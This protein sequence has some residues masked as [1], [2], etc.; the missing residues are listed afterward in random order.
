MTTGTK[1]LEA[2]ALYTGTGYHRIEHYRSGDTSPGT[3]YDD[4]LL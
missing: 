2:I 1:Q 3:Y 4:L